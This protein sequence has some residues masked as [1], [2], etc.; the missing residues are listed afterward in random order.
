MCVCF[1][2][3]K[4]TNKPRSY[5]NSSYVYMASLLEQINKALAHGVLAIVLVSALVCV[6]IYFL[7]PHSVRIEEQKNLHSCGMDNNIHL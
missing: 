7:L 1:F 6:F 5:W 3:K 4:N 2:K